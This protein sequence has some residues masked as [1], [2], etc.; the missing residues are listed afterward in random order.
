ML[1]LPLIILIALKVLS[2]FIRK[3]KI[4]EHNKLILN[5]HNKFKT[6]WGIINKD[7]G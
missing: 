5:P 2:V 7:F 3:A 1:L 4:I 6:T